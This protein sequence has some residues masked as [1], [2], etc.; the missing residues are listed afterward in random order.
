MSLL[1]KAALFV[2]KEVASS[3]STSLGTAIGE[4]VGKRIGK[5]IDPPAQETPEEKKTADKV[6]E[7]TE[8]ELVDEPEAEPTMLIR[9]VLKET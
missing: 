6:V 4:S 3:F 7:P 8:A 5:R 1:R 9:L 2:A